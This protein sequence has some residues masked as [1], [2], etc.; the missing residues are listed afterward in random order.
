MH[1]CIHIYTHN[2]YIHNTY[3]Y[4]YIHTYIHTCVHTYLR[5]YIHTYI[6]LLCTNDQPVAEAA[7]YTKHNK[8]KR[9]N[10]NPS[11]GFEPMNQAI[12]QVQ[13]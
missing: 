11:A 6:I 7:T 3:I 10:F 4:K 9:R 12:K 13:T 2:I 5:T 8:Y 1:A